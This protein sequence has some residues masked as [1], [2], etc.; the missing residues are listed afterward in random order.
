LLHSVAGSGALGHARKE[1]EW[2][3]REIR[4]R[5]HLAILL[6]LGSPRPMTGTDR[7][8]IDTSHSHVVILVS[9]A[10]LFSALAHDHRIDAPIASGSILLGER[11]AVQ[12]KFETRDLRVLDPEVPDDTRREIQQTMLG[13]RVLDAERYPE[14]LFVSTRITSTGQDRWRVAGN[15]TLHG[16]THPVTLDVN[17]TGGAYRG[18]VEI[19]QSDFGITPLRLAKG[20]V[21]VKDAV[22]I[23]FDIRLQVSASSNERKTSRIP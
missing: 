2:K 4:L 3:E 19:Q 20:I 11:A 14:I 15:L 7:R 1:T 18:S 10:G 6:L 23:R 22:Q 21:K 13:P 9:K 17:E 16:Q 12:L 8:P 5:A